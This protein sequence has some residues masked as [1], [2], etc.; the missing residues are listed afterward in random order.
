MKLTEAKLKELILET[1]E[2]MLPQGITDLLSTGD[3]GDTAMAVD[4]LQSIQDDLP[5]TQGRK[6]IDPE[7][8]IGFRIEGKDLVELINLA[9]KDLGLQIYN[10]GPKSGEEG[11]PFVDVMAPPPPYEE[12]SEEEGGEDAPYDDGSS[13]WESTVRRKL[14]KRD[15]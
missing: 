3:R 1:M 5:W 13:E 11:A 2:K 8:G 12:E 7:D 6:I 10:A 15:W 4:L 9:M 14:P